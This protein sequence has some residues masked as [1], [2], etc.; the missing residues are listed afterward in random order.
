[1]FQRWGADPAR[2]VAWL[3]AQS[4]TSLMPV[5]WQQLSH[6]LASL[7]GRSEVVLAH[8]QFGLQPTSTTYNSL[9]QAGSSLGRPPRLFHIFLEGLHEPF[10]VA[11]TRVLRNAL[12]AFLPRA[13]ESLELEPLLRRTARLCLDL[14][15][16]LQRSHLTLAALMCEDPLLSE[17]LSVQD[18]DTL[19]MQLESRVLG[20]LPAPPCGCKGEISIVAQT[21]F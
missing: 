2:A 9:T 19:W 12:E 3:R 15:T 13:D 10:W 21:P 17:A 8:W 5:Y 14:N 20:N 1:M 4:P 7:F 16:S 6:D 11:D 18:L